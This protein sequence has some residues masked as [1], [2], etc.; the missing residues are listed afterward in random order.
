M[1]MTRPTALR[2]LAAALAFL[3][4]AYVP[5]LLSLGPAGASSDLRL[6]ALLAEG[7]LLA[8]GVAFAGGVATSLTPCVYPLIPITVSV[9]GAR[10]AGSRGEAM[11][12]SG[13][14]VLG[15]AAMYSALGVGA[16]LTGKA[17]GSVMQNPWVIGFVALVLAAMAASMFGAFD[18]RLPSSWQYR[19][20]T[21][22]G[23]GRAGAFAMGLVSGIIAAPCTGPV[24]AAALTFVAAKGSV[25]FGFGVMFV[26]ALGM[27]LLFFL[28][29][30][31]SIALPKS[32]PWMDGVKSVFGVAL[33][34]AAG[35]F[36]KDAFPAVKPLFSAAR[37][38]ALLAAA[39][40]AAGVLLGALHGSF[41]A[42]GP[43]RAAKALGVLL[44]AG[45]IVYAAGASAA[46]DRR[47]AAEGFAWV[48]DEAE[49]LALAKAAGRPVIVDFWAE[50]CTACKELDKIAWADPRVR[51]EAARFVAV[52]LDGTDGS[53]AFQALTEKYGIVGMPTVL[54][55]D[56]RGREVPERVT[57]A[58]EAEEMVET[59][60]R[61][62]GACEAPAAA[63]PRPDPL[64]PVMPGAPVVACAARW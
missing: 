54:F 62:D 28:I 8:F 49:A 33:L 37:E 35:V 63:R 46:R 16:A 48:H 11:A 27:G 52:K 17:F 58:V 64:A 38:G 21:V 10:K 13:L 44:L 9:F 43:A 60:R 61:V 20:G 25:T 1:S 55:I 32:G 31:F 4:V 57:S 40:A 51:E 15:I 7:S 56:P 22:G 41:S 26:Y 12:L 14:Y 47:R 23:A 45:G 24:L 39:A 6:G 42:P 50:W 3:G 29:G 5:D 59:L 53:D 18:L 2:I 19:L 34:A 30:A 36:L